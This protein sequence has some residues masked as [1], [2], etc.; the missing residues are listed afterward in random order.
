M[1]AKYLVLIVIFILSMVGGLGYS[2]FHYHG[3]YTAL[4]NDISSQETITSNVLK[5]I[6]LMHDIAKATHDDKDAIA[7]ESQRAKADIKAAVAGDVCADSP[8]PAV[9]VSPL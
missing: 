4:Q 2:A 6:N 5:T 3:K 9:A 8:V 1:K 7:L